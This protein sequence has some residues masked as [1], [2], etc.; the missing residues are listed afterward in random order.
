MVLELDIWLKLALNSCCQVS[1]S[2]HR[3]AILTM[4][5]SVHAESFAFIYTLFD[6]YIK[7]Y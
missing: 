5:S 6:H 3:S 1:Y 2:P 4:F 7:F